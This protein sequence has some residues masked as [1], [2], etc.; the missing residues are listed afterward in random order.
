MS[1]APAAALRPDNR[2]RSGPSSWIGGSGRL[3]F[4]AAVAF[5]L[6]L[7]SCAT[8]A[9]ELRRRAEIAT[10]VGDFIFEYSDQDAGALVKVER[11]VQAAGKPLS[12]W[13]AFRDPITIHILPSHQLLERAV[14]RPG[15]DWLRAWA[16]YDEVFLQSPRTWGLIGPTQNEVNELMVH[17]LTHCMMYQL[18]ADRLS[19]SAR[20]FPLW[21]R[22][23][24][25]SYTAGQG[26]RW[27]TLDELARFLDEHP[28]VDLINHPEGLYRTESDIV[29]SAAHHAFTFLVI[30][31][32]EAKVREIL[33]AM[34]PG[35]AFPKA[36]AKALGIT[37]DD[38]A[39]DFKRYVQS[40]GFKSARTR[41]G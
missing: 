1:K 29:Y 10:E 22:E 35:L 16:R 17:E 20:E 37:A 6:V 36:F 3:E 9:P 33:I 4:C 28:D 39:A 40:R 21:F 8:H 14:N 19:W 24:M 11:T 18:S 23:G 34:R 27:P 12:R 13:G 26:Y 32:G 5:G 2:A 25:A 31:Y 38:F 30:R 7:S 15:Y 41:A